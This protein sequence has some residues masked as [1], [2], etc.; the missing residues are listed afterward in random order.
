MKVIKDRVFAGCGEDGWYLYQ[1]K[2]TGKGIEKIVLITNLARETAIT[3]AE[4]LT[5]ELMG[6]MVEIP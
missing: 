6:R 4:E 1:L 3:F 2:N 5:T